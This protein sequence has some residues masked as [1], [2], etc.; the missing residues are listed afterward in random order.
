MNLSFIGILI[1]SK[2]CFLTFSILSS[3]VSKEAKRATKYLKFFITI[4]N[5]FSLS[6]RSSKKA[7]SPFKYEQKCSTKEY[8]A[9][10]FPPIALSKN[11]ELLLSS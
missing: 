8:I 10:T 6:N 4:S 2:K 9:K 5:S 3:L 1:G 11:K 7:Y